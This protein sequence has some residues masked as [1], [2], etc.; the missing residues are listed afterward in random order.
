MANGIKDVG[1]KPMAA[2]K[3]TAKASCEGLALELSSFINLA[4]IVNTVLSYVVWLCDV[5]V[6]CLRLSY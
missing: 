4:M 1:D 3:Q 6:G 5:L 2:A